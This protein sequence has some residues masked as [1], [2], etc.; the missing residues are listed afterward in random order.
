MHQTSSVEQGTPRY[1]IVFLLSHGT[2]WRFTKAFAL[3]LKIIAPHCVNAVKR[4]ES[5]GGNTT[6]N[7]STTNHLAAVVFYITGKS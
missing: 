1:R 7:A 6:D 4:I 2:D 5:N 3:T